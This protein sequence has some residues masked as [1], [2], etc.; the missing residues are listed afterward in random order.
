MHFKLSRTWNLWKIENF[1]SS[2]KKGSH[3]ATFEFER[4]SLHSQGMNFSIE[5]TLGALLEEKNNFEL[6]SGAPQPDDS[7]DYLKITLR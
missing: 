2:A 5:T 6:N 4:R 3:F 1:L 7:I